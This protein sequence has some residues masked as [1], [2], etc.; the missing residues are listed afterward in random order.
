MA[1]AILL[2]AYTSAINGKRYST[3]VAL[4]VAAIVLTTLAAAVGVALINDAS[5]AQP[6][7]QKLQDRI[8]DK[9]D[10]EEIRTARFKYGKTARRISFFITYGFVNALDTAALLYA[11]TR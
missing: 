9:L 10:I 5:Q 6:A 11:L 4:A 8:A 3:A 2:T 1:N 7:L